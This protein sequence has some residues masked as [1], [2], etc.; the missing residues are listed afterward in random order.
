M[1]NFIHFRFLT[2]TILL[3]VL[4][5]C[6]T[7]DYIASGFSSEEEAVEEISR[8]EDELKSD[9]QDYVDS[10]GDVSESEL[11]ESETIDEES[12]LVISDEELPPV[13]TKEYDSTLIVEDEEEKVVE[14]TDDVKPD[15]KESN[16][17]KIDFERTRL[18]LSDKIQFRIATL[19]FRSGSSVVDG[20]ALRK[21]KKIV[22]MAKSRNAKVKI[23]GHASTR[24]RDMPN[25]EHKLV[26]FVI[27]DKRAQSVAKAFINYNF[28]KENLITEAVSDSKPL[29]KENMPA[30]TQANQRTEI[31]L[32]Y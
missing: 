29:F 15:F 16:A 8:A 20:K 6:G 5:S 25:S 32:I 22:E 9:L 28:P 19:A 31:F 14:T 3:F 24:T 12:Q 21:I 2:L 23:V 11:E 1:K 10:G 30:G 4:N 7:Y 26:N 13:P 27:S 17:P 18:N